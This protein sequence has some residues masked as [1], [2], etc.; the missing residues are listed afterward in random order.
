MVLG[1]IIAFLGYFLLSLGTNYGWVLIVA[2]VVLFF[3]GVFMKKIL[4]WE[5]KKGTGA[6]QIAE[7]DKG[8]F[9][10]VHED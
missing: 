5:I 8:R 10:E 6:S 7:D 4:K 9:I 3:A 1:T 2:G